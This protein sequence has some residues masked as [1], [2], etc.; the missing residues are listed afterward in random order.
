MKKWLSGLVAFAFLFIFVNVPQNAEPDWK[1]VV[2][3]T[4]DPD[5]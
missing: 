5:W 3:T 2:V 4:A 1:K